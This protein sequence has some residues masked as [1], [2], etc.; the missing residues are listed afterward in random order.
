[1]PPANTAGVFGDW[2]IGFGSGIAFRGGAAR[3]AAHVLQLGERKMMTEDEAEDS[4]EKLLRIRQIVNKHFEPDP[5]HAGRV[6]HQ[7]RTDSA[8]NSMYRIQ[9]VLDD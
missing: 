2:V 6:A 7:M 9:E 3:I 1:M 4:D 5:Y 8:V